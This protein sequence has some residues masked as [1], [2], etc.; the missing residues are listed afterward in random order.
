MWIILILVAIPIIEIALFIELGGWVGLWP[1]IALVVITAILGGLLLR[2]QGFAAMQ[3][4]QLSVAE[5]GDPRGPLAHGVMILV[6]GLLML[7]PG[8]FTDA[9]GFA[10]LLPPVRSGLIAWIGPKLAAKATFVEPGMG[11]PQMPQP[12]QPI[13]ADY[14]D[15]DLEDDPNRPRGN[16]GWS[17][18]PE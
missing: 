5:G 13:D 18:P 17:R 12:D 3:K 1:T 16:S 6:A 9:V 2:M 4:L 8:F 15:L 11:Q 7:T 14:V 10:L